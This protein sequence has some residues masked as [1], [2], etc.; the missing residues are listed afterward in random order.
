[1]TRRAVSYT[2]LGVEIAADRY[3]VWV[4]LAGVADDGVWIVELFDPVNP[5]EVDVVETIVALTTQHPVTVVAVNPQGNAATLVDPLKA[6]GMPL[7]LPDTSGMVKAW[8]EFHDRTVAGTLKHR[9]HRDLT[10]AARL[11]VG[12]RTA[13]G[14]QQVDR[15]AGRDAAPVVAAELAVYGLAAGGLGPQLF[16]WH[17]DDE[18]D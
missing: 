1:M 14:A 5:F 17:H 7:L 16:V 8:G 11:A 18:A 4:A 12:R 13:A 10:T 2:A 3:A 6:R 15:R 9:G